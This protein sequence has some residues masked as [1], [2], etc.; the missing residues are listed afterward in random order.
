MT[1]TTAVIDVHGLQW[2][3]SAA[4]GEAALSRRPGVTSVQANA[5]NQSATVAY[6]PAVTSVAELS[7]WVRD[8]GFHCAGRSVA[9]HMCEPMSGPPGQPA[10]EQPHHEH[11][12][13]AAPGNG[14]PRT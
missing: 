12:T 8:C 14:N 4:V 2:A 10:P 7:Q 9:D 3:S 1:T 13:A 11:S 5:V 6:D